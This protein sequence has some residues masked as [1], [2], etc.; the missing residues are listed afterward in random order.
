[1]GWLLVA[2]VL[3][4]CGGDGSDIDRGPSAHYLE[5]NPRWAIGLALEGPGLL[6]AFDA[7][8]GAGVWAHVDSL[9]EAGN[10]LSGPLP[11]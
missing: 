8:D 3:V 2:L 9:S 7:R 4:G 1:M 5:P 6:K 10:I 11:R